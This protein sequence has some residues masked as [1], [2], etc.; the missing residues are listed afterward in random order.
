MGRLASVT[1][2]ITN[3]SAWGNVKAIETALISEIAQ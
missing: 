3:D 2:A 1:L